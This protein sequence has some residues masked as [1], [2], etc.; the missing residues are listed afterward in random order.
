MMEE[1]R[2]GLGEVRASAS[3]GMSSAGKAKSAAAKG[4]AIGGKLF[5]LMAVLLLIGLCLGGLSLLNPFAPGTTYIPRLMFAA[6]AIGSLLAG[7]HLTSRFARQDEEDRRFWPEFG[8]AVLAAVAIGLG[9]MLGHLLLPKLFADT[10]TDVFTWVVAPSAVAVLLPVLLVWTFRAAIAFEP[11]RYQ[12]WH[13]PKN[14]REQQH[15]WNRDRIVIANFHF[16]RKEQED[17]RTTVNVKLP[18]DA[19]LGELVYLFIKDYN[20]NRFPNTPI[21]GLRR[22][23]DGM[24]WLFRKPRYLLRKQ[25]RFAWTVDVLDP[26]LTIAQ[27]GITRDSDVFFERVL[28]D[29]PA[30]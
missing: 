8:I 23:D 29:N 13:Y 15:T 10:G 18:E 3:K 21:T 7:I 9:L 12:L 11:K 22:D 5:L 17:I 26:T 6:S 24:G 25:R 19:E 14:Y 4:Q 16:K 1:Q 30:S 27:N 20:E 28:Q 2:S